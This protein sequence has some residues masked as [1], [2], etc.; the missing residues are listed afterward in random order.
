LTICSRVVNV[1][2]KISLCFFAVNNF[3]AVMDFKRRRLFDLVN[4]TMNALQ[5]LD[6]IKKTEKAQK[7]KRLWVRPWVAERPH[8]VCLYRQLEVEDAAKFMANFRM[9]PAV[10]EELL[11]RYIKQL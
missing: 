8:E 5:E 3:F 1:F 4:S 6:E 7:P 2:I 9:S 10:F 11:D